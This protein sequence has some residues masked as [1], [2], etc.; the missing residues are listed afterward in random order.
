MKRKN[1]FI[2]CGIIVAFYFAIA[3]M[4]MTKSSVVGTYV[5][6]NYHQEPFIADIPYVADTLVLKEN[7][8]F[9]SG[10]YGNGTYKVSY[11]IF[12]TEISLE[13][14][15]EMGKAGFSSSFLNKIYSTTKIILNVDSN[16]YYEKL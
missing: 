8:T 15:Y 9:S 6:T 16:Q 1:I 2:I 5:N 13:Y 4:P 10:Y 3:N 14:D 12:K 11:G 7:G